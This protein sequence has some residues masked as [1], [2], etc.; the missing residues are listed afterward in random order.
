MTTHE[1]S[2]TVA[3]LR[4]V[5]ELDLWQHA[6]ELALAGY[7][8]VPGVLSLSETS[9]L[10]SRAMDL[11]RSSTV[12]AD[13]HG[14][15]VGNLLHLDEVFL[16]VLGD[17]RVSTLLAVVLGDG[18]VLSSIQ[19]HATA[20]GATADPGPVDDPFGLRSTGGQALYATAICCLND[21]RQGHGT[22]QFVPGSHL[23]TS[24]S[25]WDA[26]NPM[27]VDCPAG[28]VIVA[29]GNL[30]RR[31]GPYDGIGSLPSIGVVAVHCR[32]FIAPREAYADL[33]ARLDADDNPVAAL[34]GVRST[35]SVPPGG[36]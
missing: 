7:A 16:R 4:D 28:S 22:V 11:L 30:W 36:P 21:W 34:L 32:D 25:G 2:P 9:S 18:A 1:L 31:F 12:G 14:R 35:R 17:D 33:A 23:V 3:L 15:R 27:S 19:I 26:A 20:A 29:N 8:V 6:A 24:R 10:R 5:A 13:S